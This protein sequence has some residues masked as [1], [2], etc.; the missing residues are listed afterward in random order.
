MPRGCATQAYAGRVY[1]CHN[2]SRRWVMQHPKSFQKN[3]GFLLLILFLW[4]MTRYLHVL[5]LHAA[6][7]GFQLYDMGFLLLPALAAFFMN[8]HWMR[9]QHRDTIRKWSLGWATAN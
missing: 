3:I 6:I 1:S 9:E 4:A 2:M 7:D 8:W 5:L